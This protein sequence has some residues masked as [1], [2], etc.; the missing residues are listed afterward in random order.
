VERG[1]GGGAT[2]ENGW[3]GSSC[4]GRSTSGGAGGEARVQQMIGREKIG[5]RAIDL[6]G[7]K[8]GGQRQDL[9]KISHPVK[10]P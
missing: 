8:M 5:T 7:G 2:V 6:S 9:E 10:F 1:A 3:R 4:G